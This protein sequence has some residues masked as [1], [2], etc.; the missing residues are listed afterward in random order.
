MSSG[1]WTGAALVVGFFVYL[2]V[3]GHLAAY[4]AILTGTGTQAATPEAAV[5]QPN[6]GTGTALPGS[7]LLT[8]TGA[9]LPVVG[10][11]PAGTSVAP[12]SPFTL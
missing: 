11:S 10:P 3:T 6:T 1:T 12:Y 4:A 9:A 7:N 5:A 8:G 2:A